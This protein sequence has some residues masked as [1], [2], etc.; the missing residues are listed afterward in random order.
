[1]LTWERSC[2]YVRFLVITATP[3]TVASCHLSSSPSL[4]AKSNVSA[5]YSYRGCCSLEAAVTSKP[6][7][8]RVLFQ[9]LVSIYL[10]GATE[11]GTST[12]SMLLLPMH[13]A[14]QPQLPW[15]IL[16]TVWD[17][18]PPHTERKEKHVLQTSLQSFLPQNYVYHTSQ[19]CRS[20]SH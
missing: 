13:W 16:K 10:A 19:A 18:K 11:N 4:T 2:F 14:L 1:M 7:I 20:N 9:K 6:G 17:R 5:W 3:G 12:H 8:K 15:I